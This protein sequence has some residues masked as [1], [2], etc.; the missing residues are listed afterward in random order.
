MSSRGDA[1]RAAWTDL[2]SPNPLLISCATSATSRATDVSCPSS[3]RNATAIGNSASAYGRI[4]NQFERF[5][6]SDAGYE[7]EQY[8]HALWAY[9]TFA[10]KCRVSE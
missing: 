8:L 10:Q 4:F 6:G 2:I 1:A 5:A 7:L 9:L 3:L